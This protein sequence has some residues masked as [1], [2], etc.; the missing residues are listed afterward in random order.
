M[1]RVIWEVFFEVVH[2]KMLVENK[3][4]VKFMAGPMC[5]NAKFILLRA[6]L[7]PNV[8]RLKY[9]LCDGP[10]GFIFG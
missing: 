10:D 5:V 7:T 6:D 3:T 8:F 9:G 1:L 4:S 2:I